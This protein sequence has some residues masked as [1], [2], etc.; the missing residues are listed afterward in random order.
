MSFTYTLMLIVCVVALRMSVFV[1][2]Q[3]RDS[4]EEKV[5]SVSLLQT[6]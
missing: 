3:P 5:C 4:D 1:S 6:V 2:Q